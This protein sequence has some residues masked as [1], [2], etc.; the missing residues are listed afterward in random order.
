MNVEILNFSNL[1]SKEQHVVADL[2]SRFTNGKSGE[3]PQMLP[4][5]PEEVMTKNWA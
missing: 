2:V 5:T 3:I 4:V 1:P